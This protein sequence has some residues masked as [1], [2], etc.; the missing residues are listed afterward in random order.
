MKLKKND[1]I[2]YSNLRNVVHRVKLS[3]GRQFEPYGISTQQAKIVNFIG[4][5]QAEGIIACQKDVEIKLKITGASVTSLLQGLD[6]KGFIRRK[7]STVD[8]RVKELFLTVKGKHL[9]SKFDAI[10]DATEK[11]ILMGM[12]VKQKKTFLELMQ[13][14][15]NNFESKTK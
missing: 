6:K 1:N 4:E 3:I 11:R 12:S 7:R 10:F 15:S 13:I 2:F 5:K 14:V 9:I 8:D